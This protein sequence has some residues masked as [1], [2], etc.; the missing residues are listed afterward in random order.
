MLDIQKLS[1]LHTLNHM[2]DQVSFEWLNTTNMLLT[3][4]FVWFWGLIDDKKWMLIDIVAC[5]LHKMLI[6]MTWV[7]DWCKNDDCTHR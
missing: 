3:L 5:L 7:T 4:S 1:K 2:Y 6:Q